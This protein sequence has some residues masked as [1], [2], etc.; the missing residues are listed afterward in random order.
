M[1]T[2]VLLSLV[3][4][5]RLI[6]DDIS[7]FTLSITPLFHVTFSDGRQLNG[8]F[9]SWPT[10]YQRKLLDVSWYLLQYNNVASEKLLS[11]IDTVLQ[12]TMQLII[13]N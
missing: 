8:P 4:N 3:K 5:G 1:L 11:A 13:F 10:E 6:V 7:K 9:I 2:D 12:S